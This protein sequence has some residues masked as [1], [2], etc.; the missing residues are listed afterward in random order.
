MFEKNAMNPAFSAST[1]FLRKPIGSR[2]MS[3]I[4]AATLAMTLPSS[5]DGKFIS[6]RT[7][8]MTTWTTTGTNCASRHSGSPN[9]ASTRTNA[10]SGSSRS[11]SVSEFQMPRNVLVTSS[12]VRPRLAIAPSMRAAAAGMT[13]DWTSSS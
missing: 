7:S 9:A 4:A 10:A 13:P 2:V 11:S 8:S 5:S 12:S 1:R 3:P 6:A